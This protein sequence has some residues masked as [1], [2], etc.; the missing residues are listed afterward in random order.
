MGHIGAFGDDRVSGVYVPKKRVRRVVCRLVVRNAGFESSGVAGTTAVEWLT[1]KVSTMLTDVGLDIKRLVADGSRGLLKSP[2]WAARKVA[3]VECGGMSRLDELTVGG[4]RTY[5]EV[6]KSGPGELVVNQAVVGRHTGIAECERVREEKPI[7]CDATQEFV[8]QGKCVELPK[9]DLKVKGGRFLDLQ[10]EVIYVRH[11]WGYKDEAG[12]LVPYPRPHLVAGHFSPTYEPGGPERPNERNRG[13]TRLYVSWD[14]KWESVDQ[15][16]LDRIGGWKVVALPDQR[17]Q[18]TVVPPGGEIFYL[19]RV[20]LVVE[21][22]PGDGNAGYEK[23]ILSCEWVLR[24][25]IGGR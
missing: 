9:M 23:E 3:D 4:A 16:L 21:T 11:E 22:T 1:E 8:Y 20:L 6:R 12:T 2:P 25:G 17:S 24:W 10:Q 15:G 13:L 14:P 18:G 19:P 7:T 5:D